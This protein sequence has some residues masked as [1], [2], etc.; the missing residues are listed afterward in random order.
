[1]DNCEQEIF[2]KVLNAYLNK[3]D[4]YL[5]V[6]NLRHIKTYFYGF[7][8]NAGQ[9]PVLENEDEDYKPLTELLTTAKNNDNE[10]GRT[11]FPDF[12]CSNG[13]IEHFKVFASKE[14]RKRGSEL[15]KELST[16]DDKVEDKFKTD[17][18]NGIL[19]E[20]YCE[21]IQVPEQSYDLFCKSFKENWNSHITSL[22]SYKE[23]HDLHNKKICFLIE[24]MS[25]GLKMKIKYPGDYIPGIH[26]GDIAKNRVNRK[27]EFNHVMIGRSK[28]LLE[29]I[30]E[31]KDMIDYVICYSN[32][33]CIEFIKTDQAKYIES[34]L[35]EYKYRSDITVISSMITDIG[36][37]KYEN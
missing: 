32:D 29:F 31:N 35:P 10:T 24:N 21:E 7:R 22:N 14:S 25:Y 13:I 9:K 27:E 16:L 34:L 18:K 11:D 1:M 8:Y 26:T 3:D 17:W 2:D 19:K 12:T 36:D 20:A 23:K 28:E 37:V 15:M 4:Y 5:T 33:G 6:K 30:Y